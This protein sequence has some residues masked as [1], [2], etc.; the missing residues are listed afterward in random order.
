MLM[1]CLSEVNGQKAISPKQKG[2]V[3]FENPRL[4]VGIVVDQMRYDFL[5]RYLNKYR[6]GGFKRMLRDGYSF[7]NCQFSYFPT[8][9]APGHASIF[10]GTTPFMHGIVGNSWFQQS[11]NQSVYCTQ[12]STVSTIGSNSK[13]GKMSPRNMQTY[14]VADQIK[15]ATNFRGKCFGVSLKD[16]GAILPAGHS[17]DAAFWFDFKSGKF[18]SSTYYGRLNGKLP[19]WLEKFHQRELP[20]KYKQLEWKPL[21][22]IEQYTEST[23][24]LAD[25]EE[26]ILDG[27]PPVFPYDLKKSREAD[28]EIIGRS[29]FGLTLSTELAKALIEGEKLGQS[30][31]M[32]FLSLSYSS[33]DIVGHSYGPFA[34]ETQD[35]YMRLDKE[36]ED[37]FT[38]LDAKVGNGKYLVFLTS[39][40]GIL[41]VPDFLEKNHL[42]SANLIGKELIENLN[43]FSRRN[44]DS[45]TLVKSYKNQQVYL[46]W[47]AID[48]K[49]WDRNWVL[50]KFIDFLEK[51]PLI[52]RAFSYYGS[53]PFPTIPYL[54]KFEAGYFKGRSGD[55]QL[56]LRP[57]IL[58]GEREK[59]TSHGAPF[60]Y[61]SHVPC[62][63]MGWKIKSG[64]THDFIQIHDIAPTLTGMLHIMEPNGCTGKPHKIPLK[65]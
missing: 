3:I 44:F 41:E 35:T 22:P 59:G 51:Q 52:Q 33:T 32:D 12:D 31:T 53:R 4:V 47:Q 21:L 1:A 20:Q 23:A 48:R 45:L 19:A 27:L 40:H 63:W 64:E 34:I 57:G 37:F 61:D 18:I 14:T 49:K 17:A 39:D 38:F 13:K 11:E 8:F 60:A 5:Y 42:P 46:D 2:S 25:Y 62:L 6:E 56:V 9:T 54:E 24:D 43:S 65:P 28:F 16:R 7:N 36:L 30:E 50:E 58:D 29:P 15:L 10:T 26:G 55:I